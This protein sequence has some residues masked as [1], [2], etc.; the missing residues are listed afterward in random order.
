M[1]S[2]F[3]TREQFRAD[4][5]T[6]VARSGV[7]QMNA[8]IKQLKH[9]YSILNGDYNR[10]T[11]L[12]D[13]LSTNQMAI[14]EVMANHEARMIQAEGDVATLKA[15]QAVMKTAITENRFDIDAA[16]SVMEQIPPAR[17]LLAEQ[18]R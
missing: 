6:E 17:K 13:T 11:A 16:L 2:N 7:G 8:E 12:V 3:V 9:D 10:V 5:R 1:K 18:R 15:E 14:M 4:V